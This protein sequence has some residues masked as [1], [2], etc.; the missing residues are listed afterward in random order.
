M[1]ISVLGIDLAKKVFQLHGVDGAGKQVLRKKL[2]RGELLR[3]IVNLK[4]CLVAMEACGSS[5]YWGREFRRLG[6]QV[7]LIPAQYVKPFVRTNKNDANDAEAIVEAALRPNIRSISIKEFEHQ[8]MQCLH[9]A[10]ER[11]IKQKVALINQIRGFFLEYGVLTPDSRHKM[12]SGLAELIE[13]S[14]AK[15]SPLI[16]EVFSDLREELKAVMERIEGMERK[17][18]RLFKQNEICQLLETI[19]GVGL[20]T[21]TAVY[22]AA[23][24]PGQFKNGRHFSASIGLV[25]RQYSSGG[26]SNLLGIS[27]RGDR[28]LRK[29]I[30]HG[31][32]TQVAMPDRRS[33]WLAEVEK[34][35]G[36]N[37]AVVAQ[38]NKTARIIWAVMAKKQ[39][40]QL[41]T[42]A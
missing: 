35:R 19:P 39:G 23:P 15:L 1:E 31:A 37:K 34:R 7:K 3:F 11:L 18:A 5:H 42:A 17:I 41:A 33:P 28:Y 21:A 9:R 10:R 4:P 27:K 36:R 40:Y 38:A 14:E 25:P 32:R 13:K 22:A 8:D 26:K 12:I 20:L 2:S 24:D 30:V 6:H 16:R 29:L